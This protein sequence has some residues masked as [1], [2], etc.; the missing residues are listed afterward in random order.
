MN[1]AKAL[2]FGQYASARGSVRPS[3]PRVEYVKE[4]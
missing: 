1:A 3:A 4:S 2:R